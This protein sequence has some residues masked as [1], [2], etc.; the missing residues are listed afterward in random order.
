MMSQSSNEDEYHKTKE[1]EC[2]KITEMGNTHL[3]NTLF[4]LKRKAKEGVLI[5]EGGGDSWENFW[6]DEWKIYEQEALDY[7]N[8]SAYKKEAIKRGIYTMTTK[9]TRQGSDDGLR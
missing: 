3:L 4:F 7:M 6:Y 8:Y 9:I 1:G 2:I 5:R